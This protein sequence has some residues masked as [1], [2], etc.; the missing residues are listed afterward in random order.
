MSDFD[1]ILMVIDVRDFGLAYL[2]GTEYR[3]YDIDQLADGKPFGRPIGRLASR[4]P[5]KDGRPPAE[6]VATAIM[7]QT[8][9][10]L[11]TAWRL[12]EQSVMP[13]GL[14]RL[15]REQAIADAFALD[16][17][18]FADLALR[19]DGYLEIAKSSQELSR[20]K[21]KD[22]FQRWVN[23][24]AGDKSDRSVVDEIVILLCGWRNNTEFSSVPDDGV[25]TK[26]MEMY[27]GSPYP[28]DRYPK[29]FHKLS[30]T[31]IRKYLREG[32]AIGPVK[33]CQPTK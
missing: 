30:D 22:D 7:V 1:W 3:E 2:R 11:I 13:I 20:K 33:R 31:T 24:S 16:P 9:E 6:I 18:H 26:L 25:V 28:K 27:N 8:A 19:F 32:G 5:T 29:K 23:K 17:G 21:A 14:F 10:S 12:G 15:G 4:N